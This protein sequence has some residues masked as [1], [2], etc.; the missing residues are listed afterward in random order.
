MKKV[1]IVTFQ[2]ADNYGAVLQCY[3]LQKIINSFDDIE[4]EVINLRPVDFQYSQEWI[5]ENEK[6]K[7]L[8]KRRQFEQFL[9]QKCNLSEEVTSVIN[10]SKYDYYCVGS[11]QIWNPRWLNREFLLPNVSDISK[12]FAYAASIGCSLSYFLSKRQIYEKYLPMFD[13]ISLR[14]KEHVGIV[15]QISGKQCECVVDPTLLLN[16]KDYEKLIFDDICNEKYVL[17]Y[18]LN[19]K[20]EIY[21]AINL[22]NKIA[23]KYKLRIKHTISTEDAK[24]YFKN[25]ECVYYSNIEEFLCLIKNAQYVV[26][27]SYHGTIFSI[28][29][30]TPFF[31]YINKSMKS[32]FETL[33]L[34]TNIE[35]RMVNDSQIEINN[36]IDFNEIKTKWEINKQISV[37]YLRKSLGVI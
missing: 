28:H 12:K 10:S 6:I 26:T 32:R 21:P 29:F 22:V 18:W 19:H 36:N 34:Y 31:T 14:E 1:G 7:W 16:E 17:F 8:R 13:S 15:S 3:A 35:D 24:V 11:D 37:N 20:Q 25:S 33:L 23:D 9:Y 30:S 2:Y 27:N 5:Y 4:A